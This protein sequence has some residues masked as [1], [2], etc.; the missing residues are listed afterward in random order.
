MTTTY[1]VEISHLG[2][3]QTIEVREDQTILQAAYD[4]G[5]D[6]PSSCN[7]GVCTTCAAQLSQGSVE[8]GDGM[9]LSPDL[10]KEGYALLCVA[11]PRSDIKLESGKEEVVYQRQ[12]GKP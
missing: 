6:L 4:A 7:A 1:K 5:I 3:T 9:G 8:Q 2:T 11:Y 10:Q 12:F